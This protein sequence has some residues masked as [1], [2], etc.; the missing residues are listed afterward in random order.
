MMI[1]T[2]H[3]IVLAAERG[4][5]HIP[6]VLVRH[7]EVRLQLIGEDLMV[8]DQAGPNGVVQRETAVDPPLRV[9]LNLR[10]QSTFREQSG[11]IQE[12]LRQHSGNIQ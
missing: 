2:H 12:T 8:V 3:P 4:Q 6:K 5:L 1:I 9:H 7:F 10:L 11:H